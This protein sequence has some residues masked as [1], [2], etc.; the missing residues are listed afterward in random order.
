MKQKHF[1]VLPIPVE[2]LKAKP[3]VQEVNREPI[4]SPEATIKMLIE[5]SSELAEKLKDQSYA[6]REPQPKVVVIALEE[7]VKNNPVDPRPAS[8][9]NKK[10]VGRKRKN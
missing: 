6:R 9:K 3:A 10:K 2:K 4:S 8:E 1:E 5:I 7:F